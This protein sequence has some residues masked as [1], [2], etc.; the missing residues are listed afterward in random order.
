[1]TKLTI[2]HF[3][4]RE[5]AYLEKS[6]R[7]GHE[8]RKISK[9]LGRYESLDKKKIKLAEDSFEKELLQKEADLRITLFTKKLQSSEYPLTFY[10][11]GKIEE[12]N[13]KYKRIMKSL[14][15]KDIEDLNKRF[16][17]NYVF[18]SNALEGNSLTLKNVAEIVFE[19][20]ISK[21]K[22][23]RE[24]YDAQ[25]SYAVFLFLQKARKKIN[26]EFIIRLHSRVMDKIDDRIGYRRVPVV[27]LGKP[28]AK[29]TKP[30]NVFKE[31]EELLQWYKNNE[32]TLHPL[33]LA[34]KFHAK[35]EK[36]H[37]FCDGNGRVG[38]F[39]LNYILMSKGYFPIIIRKT[40]RNNYV[41]ALEAADREKWLVLMRFTLK[42]YKETFRKFFE[43]YYKY[44]K[45]E[46][47]C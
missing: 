10:E 37:P 30:E 17:A 42:H 19:S 5:Y 4:G 47:V 23:L 28:L 38:R 13:L 21:G 25:N 14:H 12:M 27:L 45:V 26:H 36:I 39:L 31:M 15:K 34:V 3:K 9:Y 18:E 6:I 33:E 40:H 16:I 20:R 35:F 41:K 22:D 29:L 11:M 24:I 8:V 7:I 43:V 2:K 32:N 1:M 44:A 46:V